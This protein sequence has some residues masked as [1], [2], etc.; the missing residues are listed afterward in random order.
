MATNFGYVKQ[1]VDSQVNWGE[2]GKTFTDMLSAENKRREDLKTEIDTNTRTDLERLAQIPK[3]SSED[4]NKWTTDAA[5]KIAQARLLQVKELKSGRLS[6]KDYNNYR[7][8]TVSGVNNMVATIKSYNAWYENGMKRAEK[9][10]SGAAE[11]WKNS[12]IES[13]K[14]KDTT[15]NIGL[16]GSMSVTKLVKNPKTG[17]ME[18]SDNPADAFSFSSMLDFGKKQF[19]RFKAKESLDELDK[20]VGQYTKA[21]NQGNISTTTDIWQR[22]KTTGNFIN[23][24]VDAIKNQV[25]ASITNPNDAMSVLVDFKGVTPSGGKYEFT[26]D[27]NDP[28]LKGADRENIIFMDATMSPQLTEG[29]MKRAED[30]MI[31]GLIARSGH[32]ET[33]FT[34]PRYSSGTISDAQLKAQ[35]ERRNKAGYVKDT[36]VMQTGSPSQFQST[37]KDRV[38]EMNKILKADRMKIGEVQ[39]TDTEYI[40]PIYKYN[41]N[42]KLNDL[43]YDN[44]SRVDAQ[45]N[46]LPI[47]QVGRELSRVFTPIKGSWENTL[48]DVG[49][50]GNAKPAM[51]GGKGGSNQQRVIPTVTLSSIPMKSSEGKSVNAATALKDAIIDGGIDETAT[52][53]QNTF[54]EALGDLGSKIKVS[55]DGDDIIIEA[56]GKRINYEYKDDMIPD[57]TRGLNN[58]INNNIKSI[59]AKNAAKSKTAAKG[60][61]KADNNN[62]L[63]L[64]LN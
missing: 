49:G 56:N 41:P 58:I 18:V 12:L 37:V 50:Y 31:E 36:F 27:P 25:K 9:M 39:R 62:P 26:N 1:N 6:L 7:Q 14:F 42:T 28:R 2:V 63:N 44:I 34:P 13:M 38:T 15:P 5:D 60:A 47:E 52:V 46:P 17:L 40:I 16:D 4:Y 11:I 29:Q 20:V 32:V 61:V 53:I 3:G 45:G 8:N 54:D 48:Q 30:V 23:P 59:N 33:P 22:D 51:T 35:D 10:E 57:L 19:N 43:T 64:K 55:H 24:A 21:I